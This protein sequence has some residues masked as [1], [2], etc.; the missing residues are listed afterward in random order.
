VAAAYGVVIGVKGSKSKEDL[1]VQL[2]RTIKAIKGTR[3]TAVNLFWALKRMKKVFEKHKGGSLG[4]I[5]QKLECEAMEIHM[6]DKKRC[7]AI[8]RNGARLIRHG[9]TVLT[10][11][12]AGALAT[13]GIGTALACIYKARDEGKDPRVFACETRPLLQGARLTAWE[14][15]EAGIDVTLIC[16]NMVGSV[17]QEGEIDLVITGADRISRNGDTANK[18]GTYQL[19]VLS[20]AHNVPFYVAAP[21]ST[22]DLSTPNGSKIPI[23]KRGSDE[24]I[25]GFG[26]RIA[27]EGINVYSPAFDITPARLIKGIITEK[28]IAR[29]PYEE[30][31][32]GLG[33]QGPKRTS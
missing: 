31:L 3:P 22:L 16:D 25:Y 19:A 30:S 11:C 33:R 18:I 24:V 17:M 27:P 7:E 4:E 26:R 9:D 29:P 13:G 14:L 12:N 1:R 2:D 21:I 15:K 23:E 20:E 28:G 32:P 6:E 5:L 10:I 8:G